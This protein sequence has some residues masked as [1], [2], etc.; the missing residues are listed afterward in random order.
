MFDAAMD[1]Y[2]FKFGKP[3]DSDPRLGIHKGKISLSNQELQPLFDAVI[4][5]IIMSCS[6][7]LINKKSEVR[8]SEV[9]K[10]TGRRYAF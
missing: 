9:R 7:A 2:T 8:K 10:R 6:R 4:N 5:K 1:K 3:T